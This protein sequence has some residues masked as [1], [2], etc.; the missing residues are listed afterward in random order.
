M[1]DSAKSLVF[2]RECIHI[3]EFWKRQWQ[4]ADEDN[5]EDGKDDIT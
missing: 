4:N 3:K 1:D 2:M 5:I